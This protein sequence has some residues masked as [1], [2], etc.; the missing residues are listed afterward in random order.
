MRDYLGVQF[1]LGTKTFMRN[2]AA[3]RWY[4]YQDGQKILP[5][6]FKD[7][8][9]FQAYPDRVIVVGTRPLKTR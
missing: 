6:T 2:Q 3:G 1:G 7:V 9:Y 8:M 4:L 5:D